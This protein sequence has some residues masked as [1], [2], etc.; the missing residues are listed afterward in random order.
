[1][2]TSK[3]TNRREFLQR[4][5]ATG[6]ALGMGYWVS[7]R[8]FG[9]SEA[10]KLP[11]SPNEKLSIAVIG[12]ARRGAADL[13]EIDM[14]IAP[15]EVVPLDLTRDREVLLAVDLEVDDRGRTVRRVEEV[16]EVLAR[17]RD[18]DGLEAVAVQHAGHEPFRAEPT[19]GTLAAPVARGGL[20]DGFHGR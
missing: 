13:E 14:H 4:S 11:T 5:A 1:M 16:E 20:Q 17:H 3:R 10:T 7:P 19:G 2:S 15:V 8:C 12:V 18:R 6:A 9:Q